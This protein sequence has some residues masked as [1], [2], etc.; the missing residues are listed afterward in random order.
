MTARQAAVVGVGST[1]VH[2]RTERTLVDL[3]LEAAQAAL[4]DAGITWED[5][6][7][8]A[9]SPGAPNASAL[10]ADGY[11]EVSV[12][13]AVERFGL[14]RLR[15]SADV[16]GM[17]T[18]M[19]VA[20]AAAVQA[21]LCET[22]LCLRAIFAPPGAYA[23]SPRLECPGADQLTLPYGFG[24]GGG[25]HAM[26]LRRYLHDHDLPDGCLYPVVE[27]SRKAAARNPVA[28]WRG[29]TV[30][31]DEYLAS[32]YVVEP[33]RLYDCDIPVTGA[34]ALVVTTRAR[35]ADCRHRPAFVTAMANQSSA[36]D[37][38]AMAGITREDVDVCQLYDGYS[39]FLLYWLERLGFCG[40][41]EAAAYI[42]GGALEAGGALPTNTFGGALGEGRLHGIGHVREA[43]LQVMGRAG[44]RQVPGAVHCLVQV[45]V[46]ERSWLLLLSGA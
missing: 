8:Y 25:R 42:A 17:A 39:S 45:G 21:G 34:G 46:Q 6:D 19:V 31:R 29:S 20:A 44:A 1:P 13:L 24:P 18:G 16:S 23:R 4:D 32:R 33:L 30:S 28:Y 11:D 22:V 40:P 5:V 27:A 10:H 3:A 26:W 12:N 35:A 15:W 36:P 38:F 43:A 2:R 14:H 7:G 37:I 41:G 9:G